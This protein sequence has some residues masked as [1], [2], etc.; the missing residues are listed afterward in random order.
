MHAIHSGTTLNTIQKTSRMKAI[1][2]K[3]NHPVLKYLTLFVFC[4]H[5]KVIHYLVL[6]NCFF[7]LSIEQS[8]LCAENWLAQI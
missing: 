2:I 3:F 4:L 1:D 7:T 6:D 5:I 8:W